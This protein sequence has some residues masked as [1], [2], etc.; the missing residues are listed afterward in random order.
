MIEIHLAPE[1]ELVIVEQA[2][3]QD[4]REGWWKDHLIHAPVGPSNTN[5][6]RTGSF[7]IARV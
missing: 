3:L 6:L 7:L 5:S 4:E 1:G 2:R